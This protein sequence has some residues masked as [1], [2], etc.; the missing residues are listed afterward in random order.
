MS[1]IFRGGGEGGG[2]GGGGGGDF[3]AKVGKK[4][5]RNDSTRKLWN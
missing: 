3:N 4:E 5:C 2:G 1:L